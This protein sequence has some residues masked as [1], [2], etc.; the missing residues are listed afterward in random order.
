MEQQITALAIMNRQQFETIIESDMSVQEAEENEKES[1]SSDSSSSSSSESSNEDDLESP[2][3][4][5]SSSSSDSEVEEE[6]GEA[7]TGSRV[8]IRDLEASL[9]V[10]SNPSSVLPLKVR[11]AK[12]ST[13]KRRPKRI[14]FKDDRPP[15]ILDIDEETDAD[16]FAVLDDWCNRV[17]SNMLL[18]VIIIDYY[19][20]SRR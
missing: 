6:E 17:S 13:V 1:L 3:S 20:G 19:P 9:S 8:A 15:F 16:I 11:A 12:P 18:Y 10:S 7:A 4:S 5:S 2:S 14:L